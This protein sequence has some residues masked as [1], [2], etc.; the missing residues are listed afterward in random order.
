MKLENQSS[1]DYILE[2]SREYSIYICQ[3]R[4]IPRIEDGLKDSQRKALWLIRNLNEKIKT[5]SLSGSMLSSNL[6]IHGD[7]SASATISMLAAPYCNNIPLLQGIGA[8][9]TR[10]APVEGI[11]APRY[12]YVKRGKAL[13]ELIFTDLDIVPTQENYDGSNIE[14]QHFLPLIPIVLLNGISGIASGWSTE[15]LPRSFKDIVEATIDALDQK[16]IKQLVP[17]YDYLQCH[18]SHLEDNTWQL[19]GKANI[20]DSSTIKVTEL[21]PDLTLEKFKER[22]NEFE[23]K[24]LING[25]IDRSTKFIEVSVKFPRGSIKDWTDTKAIDFL[26]LRQKKT[27]RIV[28]VDWNGKTITQYTSAE[29]VIAKF[30]TWRLKWYSIRYQTRLDAD[31][32]ELKYWQAL[33]A[34]F[35]YGLP[36]RIGSKANRVEVEQ[37]VTS[38]TKSIGID[39]KQMDKVVSLPSFR[40][41]RDFEI[42]IKQ[43]IQSL[44]DRIKDYQD[45][46]AKPSRIKSIYRSEL[47]DLKKQKF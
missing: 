16:P 4:A 11:G 28:V 36:A 3:S 20:A 46:L 41:A 6:Y 35:A 8:F 12:T 9:G 47:I 15:I 29:D 22:L 26:K 32:Y 18:I 13:S 23:D 24:G 21:P 25:Y 1:S 7:A 14:P 19:S 34:C 27:E 43:N 2:T 45:I 10:T 17:C 33:E 38:I 5:V 42:T 37:D 31:C 40:W 39:S 30:V 44:T